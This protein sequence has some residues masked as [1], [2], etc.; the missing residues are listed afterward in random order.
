MKI[1]CMCTFKYAAVIIYIYIYTYI[2]ENSTFRCLLQNGNGNGT[3]QFV[4]CNR[5]TEFV[6]LGR[7]TINGNGRLLFQQTCPSMLSSKYGVTFVLLPL[8]PGLPEQLQSPFR[9]LGDVLSS[10]FVLPRQ[11][12]PLLLRVNTH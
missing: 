6:F 4:F 11:Y 8:F 5:K 10:F 9:Y 7:R 3:L 1:S 2:T 12:F